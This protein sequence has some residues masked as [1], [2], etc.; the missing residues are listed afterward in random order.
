M[1]LT[2]T[3][4]A[5]LL[6]VFSVSAQTT[7][8]GI[9]TDGSNNG[10]AGATI[11]IDEST[12]STVSDANG[13]FSIE[14]TDGYETLI[15]SAEGFQ[16]RKIYL[17]GQNSITVK[18]NS[19]SAG[20]QINMGIGSQ[21]KDELTSSV[22]SIDA[23]D[24]SPAPLIN[25]EQANQ[26]VTAGLFVQNSSGKLGQGTTVRIRGGSSLSASNQPLY[27]IDGVPL[28]SGNQSNINPSN[29]ASIEILKDAAATAIY[30][31]R[32]AN[33]VIIITTKSGNAGEMQINLDYQLGISQTPK[34]LD[35]QSGDE[36]RLQT[37]ESI[38]R[39]FM[40]GVEPFTIS[41]EIRIDGTDYTITK[42]FLDNFY[43]AGLT[44]VT[45]VDDP[46]NQTFTFNMP[47]FYSQLDGNTDWQKEVF[48][49]APSHRANIDVQGGTQQLG[50]FASV[51][52]TTQEG[53]LIGNKFDR[54]NG[55]LS[56]NSKITDKLSANLNFNYIFTEDNRLN[57]DQDLGAPLQ[58]IVL[59]PSDS[60]D[61][62]N[63]YRLNVRS[64]EYNPLTEINFADN[65]ATN[66][67]MIGSLGFNYKFSEKV[68]IDVNGGIDRSDI[69]AERR[70]GP[71]TLDGAPNG[72]SSISEQMVENYV[73]NGWLTYTPEVSGNNKLSLILGG[74][75][76][77]S[78]TS[79]D[80]RQANVNSISTLE[81]LTDSDPSLFN[82]PIQGD[83]NVFLSSY[84]RVSYS[85]GNLY[86][87]QVTGRMD[88]SSKFSEDNRFGYF[89]AVSAGWNIHN[90][91]GFDSPTWSQ[92]KLRASYG[93]VG[94]APTDDF[95]YRRNYIRTRY[96][97][98]DAVEFANLSN[99]N[100]KWETTSQL[101]VGID[102]GLTAKNITGSVD[103][104]IKTTTDL[105]F[106]VPVSQTSGLST[107]FDNIGSMENKGF[108]IN[109]SSINVNN[110]DF[111]W[112]TDFNI[113]FNDNVI[114][115]LNGEQAIVGVNAFLENR[116]AGV[117]YMRKYAG[118]D[119]DTGEALYDDGDGGTTDNWEEAPRQEVGNPN[120]DFFGGLTNSITYKNWEFS[121]MFQFV[122]GVDLYFA[123]GEYLANSGIL[124]LG[125]LTRESNRWYE[126]GDE[127]PYPVLNPF[128]DEPNASTRWLEDGSYVRL[129]NITLTYNFPE[130]ALSNMGLR[131]F[132]IYVGA[133]NLF[134][135]TDY[136]GYDP[137]VSYFDPLDGIIG[138]NISRGI[139]NFTA[140]QPR[141]FMSGIK[142]GF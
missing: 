50:Y 64:L 139:D 104:Y 8:R 56:L 135:I 3:C 30:G 25:L 111:S 73:T 95:L 108:E 36:H 85:I 80:F 127:A 22:S 137:D 126:P 1:K 10:I 29:I 40:I 57:E 23:A 113:S 72:R 92:L 68:S 11:K 129:K 140:P 49:N 9:V 82:E 28:T 67:S 65:V 63:N 44:D 41:P 128:Q 97:D 17:T 78:T 71:E 35:I 48:R 42:E 53:I 86:D 55:S 39:G 58:A 114:T 24:V 31:T 109:I 96:N 138:Q 103:Y 131:N 130:A 4:L 37:F 141:I 107:I 91:T 101:N 88:G 38:L 118:V 26:G 20:N 12:N 81:S 16:V 66:N 115:D 51:G 34:F 90:M 21:S 76:Q 15:I 133:T 32:A 102:F 7:L 46:S 110:T 89:P 94:N 136:I 79:F 93:L 2:L 77:K 99:E 33:G 83:A 13:N 84:A 74:S 119:P 5:S 106:P 59:P 100:L 45:I 69:R 123:T 75:Y 54:L 62:A 112:T 70:Q 132:S 60:Y 61:P 134:T 27:V 19:L 124:N 125:Q 120:P 105:L 116:P 6:L 43:N 117:F 47:S 121:T 142:I 52:Y 87:I 122:G 98:E 18:M 14:L